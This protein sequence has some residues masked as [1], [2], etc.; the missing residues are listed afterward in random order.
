MRWL[1]SLV[2]LW[3]AAAKAQLPPPV[4]QALARAGIAETGVGLFVQ[5]VGA[6]EPTLVHRGDLPLNPAS[7]MQLVT[8]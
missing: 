6:P 2:L 5:D 3:A 8:T 7:V 1:L 4:A